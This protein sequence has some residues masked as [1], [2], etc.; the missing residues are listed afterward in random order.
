MAIKDYTEEFNHGRYASNLMNLME[1][2]TKCLEEAEKFGANYYE[3]N[4][5]IAAREKI[6]EA[7]HSYFVRHRIETKEEREKRMAEEAAD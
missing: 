5:L 4:R 7:E 1:T 6:Y 3:R 2:I